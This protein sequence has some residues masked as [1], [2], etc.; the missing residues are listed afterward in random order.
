MYLKMNLLPLIFILTNLIND[1]TGICL[2]G[3]GGCLTCLGLFSNCATCIA[4]GN[5]YKS[6]NFF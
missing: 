5:I 4:S 2:S 6:C 3:F 1:C